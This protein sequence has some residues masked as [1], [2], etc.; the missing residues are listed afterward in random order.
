MKWLYGFVGLLVTAVAIAVFLYVLVYPSN[1]VRYR[2]TAEVE[3]PEGIQTG[4]VVNDILFYTQ[5][6]TLTQ[7]SVGRG[8]RVRGEAL[9][10]DLGERGKLFGLLIG[11]LSDGSTGDPRPAQMIL[12]LYA[13]DWRNGEAGYRHAISILKPTETPQ[14]LPKKY[15][16]F[17]VTFRDPGDPT[18][19]E[20]VDTDNLADRF[21]SGVKL[22]RMTTQLVDAGTWPLDGIGLSGTPRTSKIEELL[23]WLDWPRE[24][25]LKAGGGSSPL[26]MSNKKTKGTIFL[27]RPHFFKE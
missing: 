9:V 11:K 25:R 14:A 6:T 15:W 16:P 22:T 17:F 1:A 26:K 10:V 20:S 8:N 2:L 5:P 21:G 3:T 13:P 18:T 12:D 27:D 4:S 23:P 19:V 24:K 7:G